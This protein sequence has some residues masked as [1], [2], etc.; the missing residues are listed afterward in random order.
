MQS[1]SAPGNLVRFSVD[2]V[3]LEGNLS[4][5]LRASGVTAYLLSQS[6]LWIIGAFRPEGEVG[7]YFGALRLVFYGLGIFW[8][9][10]R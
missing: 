8:R 1:D 2:E 4:L 9:R 6:P 7:L 5:P 10:L 3:I